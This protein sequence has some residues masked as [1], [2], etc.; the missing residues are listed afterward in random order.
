M[1]KRFRIWKWKR[2]WSRILYLGEWRKEEN[3]EK[4]REGDYERNDNVKR[5]GILKE[6][7][8]RNKYWK[9]NNSKREGSNEGRRY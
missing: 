7:R 5:E 4:R 2:K 9:N 8:F 6:G 1:E 3:L